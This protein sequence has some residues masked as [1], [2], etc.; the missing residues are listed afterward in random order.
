M[1]PDTKLT[2][3][4]DNCVQVPGGLADKQIGPASVNL[5]LGHSIATPEWYWNNAI[6]RAMIWSLEQHGKVYRRW[7]DEDHYRRTGYK[8]YRRFSK[9]RSFS[10][11]TLYPGKFVLA[12]SLERTF[13]PPHL[14][15]ILFS[16]S[17]TGR[18][19]IEHLHAGF[20][21]SG[22]NGQWVFELT[23]D[24]PW[25]FV[26]RPGQMLMQLALLKMDEAPFA[27]YNQ[28]GHYQGQ[29]GVTQSRV[30]L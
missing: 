21:D 30:H 19:G 1:L 2:E 11:Y 29:S 22:F 14:V 8:R 27:D 12:H 17:S 15:G 10:R 20:G 18:E 5:R 24:A 16:R 7:L 9:P 3:W 23:N 4:F 6:T 25:P 13:I 26:L 28:V